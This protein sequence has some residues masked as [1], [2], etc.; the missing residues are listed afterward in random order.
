MSTS[1]D[2]KRPCPIC[3]FV[4]EYSVGSA[5]RGRELLMIWNMDWCGHQFTSDKFY[6]TA[7]GWAG[8]RDGEREGPRC[9][10]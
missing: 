6:R 4:G 8:W 2:V 5:Y 3:M 9:E 7:S 1:I 10:E